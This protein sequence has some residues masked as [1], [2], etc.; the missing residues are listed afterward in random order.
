MSIP[1]VYASLLLCFAG[2][3]TLSQAATVWNG[4]LVNFTESGSTPSDTVLAGKVVLTRGG[5]NV[6]YNTAAGET[7]AGVSSPLDTE[8]GFG[9][10]NNFASLTYQSLASLRDGDLAARILNQ[11]M[12]MHIVSRDIYLSVE[13]T[14]WGQHGAGGFSYTRSTPAAAVP[15]TVNIT[16]P[17][18][19]A[20]FAAPASVDLTSDAAVTG[21]T[22]TNVQYFAGSTLLGAATTSPFHVTGNIPNAGAYDLKA[23]A[24]AAGISATSAVVHITV[25]A[26]P[27]VTLTQPVN[28][29]TL[30]A[31]ANVTLAADATVSG[32]T[33][34]NVSFFNDAT[35]LGSVQTAPFS[36]QATGLPAGSYALTAVATAGGL[37]STS[38]VVNL[39]IIAPAEVLLSEPTATGGLFSFTYPA[40]PGLTYVVERSSNL[41]DWSPVATNVPSSGSVVFSEP[42]DLT[43]PHYYRVG[44]VQNP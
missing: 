16:S 19:G 34:T 27:A 11:P 38:A 15:P 25:V 3:V 4:P 18:A 21:G 13:F 41:A 44:R 1:K 33:V 32:D 42:L 10:L 9:T 14:A 6:L 20:V 2:S 7:F 24:T 26:A 5:N 17:A 8:W 29:T 23:V 43:G 22:V 30:T 39:T 12:V 31:P 28:G 37:S 36:F 40:T 35:L